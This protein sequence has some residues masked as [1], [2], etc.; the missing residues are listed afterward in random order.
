MFSVKATHPRIDPYLHAKN[1]QEVDIDIKGVVQIEMIAFIILGL[2]LSLS[3][4]QKKY[5]PLRPP[6][7]EGIQMISLIPLPITIFFEGLRQCASIMANEL[8]GTG[9]LPN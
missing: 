1:L 3:A 9:R 8:N 6:F 5:F 7:Q 4:A 2:T